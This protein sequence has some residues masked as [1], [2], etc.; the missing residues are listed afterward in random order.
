LH[1]SQKF[2]FD[3]GI[4]FSHFDKTFTKSFRR[5]L[6]VGVLGLYRMAETIYGLAL[7]VAAI[8][9]PAAILQTFKYRS[10]KLKIG[11]WNAGSRREEHDKSDLRRCKNS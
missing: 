1:P 6:G 8:G 4:T 11:V 2:A 5:Y 3:V 9:I 10:A 7:L